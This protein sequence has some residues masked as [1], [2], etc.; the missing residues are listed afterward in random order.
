MCRASDENALEIDFEAID[1]SSRRMALSSSIGNGLK[2]TTKILTSKLSENSC[3]TNPL[4]DYLLSLNHQGEVNKG[5]T[6]S[7]I[8]MC[9]NKKEVKIDLLIVE[10]QKLKVIAYFFYHSV[11]SYDQ[12]HFECHTKASESTASY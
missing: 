10:K 5:I 4:L 12:R 9:A 7:N 8:E 6:L 2:F 1:F 3:S 11:E